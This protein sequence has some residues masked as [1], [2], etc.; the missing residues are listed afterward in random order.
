MRRAAML[1]ALRDVQKPELWKVGMGVLFGLV[2]LQIDGTGLD[3]L[4]RF[5]GLGIKRSPMA[6][7]CVEY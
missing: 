3:S 1:Q 5:P 2:L 6:T 4:F 7:M